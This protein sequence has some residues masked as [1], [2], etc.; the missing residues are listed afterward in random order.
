MEHERA[1][2]FLQVSYPLKGFEMRKV[3]SRWAKR[4]LDAGAYMIMLES[5]GVTENVKTW[6]TEVTA[7]MANALG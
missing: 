2:S 5:E 7:K 3:R 6:R 4:L 1:F